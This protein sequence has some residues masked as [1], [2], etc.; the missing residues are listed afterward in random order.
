[1]PAPVAEIAEV[2]P[3]PPEATVSGYALDVA[4]RLVDVGAPMGAPVT[5]IAACV[6]AE[7]GRV[8]MAADSIATDRNA[9]TSRLI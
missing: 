5:V 9:T 3:L 2:L 4:G 6:D 7:A 1:V 8:H